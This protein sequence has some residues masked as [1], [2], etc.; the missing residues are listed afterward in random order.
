MAPGYRLN[1]SVRS[2]GLAECH[3]GRASWNAIPEINT[4]QEGNPACGATTRAYFTEVVKHHQ[5]SKRNLTK[6]V[7]WRS[8]EGGVR[9]ICSH[10]YGCR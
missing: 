8:F 2:E 6:T 5:H 3:A 1:R 7:N 4:E 9:T 10:L